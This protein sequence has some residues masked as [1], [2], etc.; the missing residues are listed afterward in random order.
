MKLINSYNKPSFCQLVITMLLL[1]FCLFS[2]PT[3]ATAEPKVYDYAGVFSIEELE[4]LEASAKSLSETY[5]MDIGIVTTNDNEGKTTKEYSDDFYDNNG[6]GYGP[7]ASGLI[8]VYDAQNGEIYISTSGESI[9]YFTDNRIDKMLDSIYT[10]AS[11]GNFYDSAQDY[12]KNVEYYILQ[13]IP[14]DQRTVDAPHVPFTNSKGQPLNA[15]SIGLSAIVAMLLSAIIT[16]IIRAIIIYRYKHPRYT[17]PA[18]I[19]D[20]SSVHYTEREDRFVTSHTTKTKI[21]KSTSSS[22]NISSTHRS[23]SGR[24]HGGGGRKL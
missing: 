11:K 19:P 7:E 4:S 21:E 14:A 6:Y 18:T 22:G 9:K 16:L 5:Q 23:S 3:Y 12:L 24:T 8:Y 15:T 10:Y 2:I 13:G 17:E 1:C 20:D